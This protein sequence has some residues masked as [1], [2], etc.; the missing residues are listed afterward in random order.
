MAASVP[1]DFEV[2]GAVGHVTLN[3]PDVRNAI[4]QLMRD[5]LVSTLEEAA[6]DPR[7]RVLIIGGAGDR[8]FC[9]GADITEFQPPASLV[10]ARRIREANRFTD[11]IANLP[12][13][14]IAAIHG[15]CL[16]GGLEIAAACDIRLA[17]SNAVFGFPEVSLGIV[18]G[19]GGTQRV[20]RLIGLG[21]A[22]WLVLTA[23]RINASEALRIGLVSEV[24][25]PEQLAATAEA[26]ADRIAGY[27]PVALAYAKEA[28]TRGYDLSI[29]EGLRL[30]TDLATLI[31][32]TSDRLEGAAAFRERRRPT[33]R[34]E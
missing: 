18:P 23:E 21:S 7:V 16:G 33:Y 2:R 13:P 4:N 26:L 30:E 32:S 22:L 14:T 29:A 28:I 12:K 1:V 25:E 8:A 5:A 3:R 11:S 6:G 19:V 24:V 15:Y 34:G 9:A 17:A 31:T 10:A 27:G 20:A